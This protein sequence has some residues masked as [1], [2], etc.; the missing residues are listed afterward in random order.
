M[1]DVKMKSTTQYICRNCG[2]A[3]T[4][5][6][7]E[8]KM[9]CDHCGSRFAM[10][11][12]ASSE[13]TETLGGA[14]WGE[15]KDKVKAYACSSCGAELIS[16]ELSLITQ[17][18]YCGNHSVLEYKFEGTLRPQYIIPFEIT[19]EKAIELLKTDIS[20]KEMVNKS[21]KTKNQIESIA[22]M[23]VPFWNYSAEAYVSG[24]FIGKV[25]LSEDKESVMG[26]MDIKAK[27]V[28]DDI[29]VDGSKKMKDNY[30]DS[31][32]PY[33]FQSKKPFSGAYMVG[34]LAERFDVD[35]MSSRA[36]AEARMKHT[37]LVFVSKKYELY[38]T[39]FDCPLEKLI[40]RYKPLPPS[41]SSFVAPDNPNVQFRYSKSEYVMAPVWLATIKHKRKT[42]LFAVNG[43]TGLVAGNK[44]ESKLRRFIYAAIAT[45]ATIVVC[46][47]SFFLAVMVAILG[48]VFVTHTDNNTA[49]KDEATENVDY[50]KCEFNSLEDVILSNGTKFANAKNAYA[51]ERKMLL[52][53]MKKKNK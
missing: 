5:S 42:Y 51:K 40:P 7:K 2:G 19:K 24:P 31:L 34:F 13:N 14:G 4:F 41:M 53:W 20:S 25:K 10:S 48:F 47:F 32:E 44:P 46:F 21:F 18:P 9:I 15:L 12:Y 35:D 3:T 27:M 36:R 39:K 29:S 38:P 26:T 43:Q 30:M 6:A 28:F 33:N 37:S 49:E 16:D 17:C 22:G 23:Y 11:E 1:E 8:G 52:K 50:S 45:A